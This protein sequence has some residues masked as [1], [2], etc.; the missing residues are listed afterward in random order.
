MK[1]YPDG[2]L[3]GTPEEL[4]AYDVAKA[5]LDRTPQERAP[6]LLPIPLPNPA[7]APWYATFPKT[8]LHT[9]PCGCR[10]DTACICT[11]RG[12]TVTS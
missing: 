3:E 11:L 12:L 4:A 5:R 9:E 8:R 6:I 2:T 7:S 10:H 1:I